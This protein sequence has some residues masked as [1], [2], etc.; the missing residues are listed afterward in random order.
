MEL[1]SY[2][3]LFGSRRSCARAVFTIFHSSTDSRL[4]IGIGADAYLVGSPARE[5]VNY[6]EAGVA[7]VFEIL[8]SS[9]IQ[10]VSQVLPPSSEK[11]CSK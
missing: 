8:V 3:A 7:L 11:A 10:F 5:V 2:C 4:Y 1:S 6:Q 9:A